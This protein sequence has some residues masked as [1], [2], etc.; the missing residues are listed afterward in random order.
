[1][2]R[3][4]ILSPG[5]PD[6]P[7]GV[8][9][10]TARLAR[11]WSDSG[12]KVGVFGKTSEPIS[13][14]AGELKTERVEGLLLQY[15]PF[16]YGRRGLST[17]PRAVATSCRALGIGVTTFVHEP[18]VPPTRWQWLALS[19]LQRRQLRRL[20]AVSN[21]VVTA[22]PKWA[23]ELGPATETLYVGSTLGDPP[24]DIEFEP[25]LTA[26]VVFSP[27]AAGLRW[28]WIAAAAAAIGAGLIVI[29]GDRETASRHPNLRGYAAA[30]WD[31]RGRV[32][33]E[34]ALRLLARARLVLA[35]FVDGLTG[36]RTSAM[37]ALSC[38]SRLLTSNGHLS[39]PNFAGG[40]AI[41]AETK[42]RYSRTAAELWAVDDPPSEREDRITWFERHLSPAVLDSRLLAIVTEQRNR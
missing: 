14:L 13:S 2:S 36:R 38:G 6:A 37:A 8:T 35:P 22:V 15:V 17:F 30:G 7:G 28:D 3:V 23:S 27:F 19:P 42:D 33:A 26:P 12:A 40:P 39:D 20:V 32:S 9:D 25:P 18:W 4:A 21:S 5:Y 16:L 1:M 31:Y 41:V 29:G 24:S 34:Q 11:S 10:H